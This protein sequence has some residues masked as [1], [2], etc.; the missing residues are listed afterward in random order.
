MKTAR[1]WHVGP[2]GAVEC[3]LC[4]QGC[5]L[6]EGKTG[7]CGVRTA[8]QG[9]L[10]SDGYGLVSSVA[11]DPIEKKPLYHF[12]PG[13][14]ILSVGGWGCNFDCHFCQNWAI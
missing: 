13:A 9:A 4:P 5:R 8:R 6:A 12:H 10:E 11:V 7:L 3:D 1:F 14:G 2:D